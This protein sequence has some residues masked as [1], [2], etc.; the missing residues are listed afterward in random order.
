MIGLASGSWGQVIANNPEVAHFTIVEI[1]PGYIQL[2]RERPEV[3]S[4]LKIRKSG[5]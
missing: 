5:L 4:L 1:N 2:I 3:S